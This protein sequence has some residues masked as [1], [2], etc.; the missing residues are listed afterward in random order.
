VP[1]AEADKPLCFAIMPITTP[2]DAVAK[3][4]GDAKHFIKVARHI[5]KPAAEAAGFEF[6]APASTRA[7]VIQ[8]EIIE[9]LEKADLVLCDVSTW[10][11]NAFFELGIRVALD[12]PV[13]MVRDD[14]TAHLPFDNSIVNTH[15]YRASLQIDVVEE[16]IP[17]LAA[18]IQTAATQQQNALWKHFGI[19]QRA[20]QVDAG[21]PGDA[22]LV[23]RH[24]GSTR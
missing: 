16:Q 1:P 14:L 19:T 18:F 21:S 5:F 13:A 12:R 24:A 23:A 2:D 11:A 17:L 20:H 10:N 4:G 22:K 3:Y 6:K 15:T 9:H 7:E 8:A